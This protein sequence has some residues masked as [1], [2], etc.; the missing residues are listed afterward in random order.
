MS[1]ALNKVIEFKRDMIRDFLGKCTEAQV[2]LF[3]IM[4]GSVDKLPTDKMDWALQ[5]CERTVAKNEAKN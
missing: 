3:N 2:N 4:Y 5:Q 1:E